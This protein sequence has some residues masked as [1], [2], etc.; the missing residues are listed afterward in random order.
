ML[1]L[2]TLRIMICRSAHLLYV[3]IYS[4]LPEDRK[5]VTKWIR[6]LWAPDVRLDTKLEDFSSTRD[7]LTSAVK[8]RT[9]AWS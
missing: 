6:Y 7:D 5:N 4:H 9:T 2:F 1:G 8:V 3:T